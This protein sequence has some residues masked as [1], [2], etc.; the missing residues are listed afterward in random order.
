MCDGPFG[1]RP[2]FNEGFIN[3]LVMWNTRKEKPH[4]HNMV[5]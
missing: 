3:L 1:G 2:R 4:I 5:T